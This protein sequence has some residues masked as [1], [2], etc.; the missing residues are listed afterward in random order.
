L[1]EYVVLHAERPPELLTREAELD[2]LHG[3]DAGEARGL[4]LISYD[5]LQQRIMAVIRADADLPDDA[6]PEHPL[7]RLYRRMADDEVERLAE[8][9]EGT[10]YATLM[11]LAPAYVD[12]DKPMG[13]QGL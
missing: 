2:R 1:R 7:C 3:V 5:A 4:A 13:E 12:V 6:T 9:P 11:D 10:F 8:T